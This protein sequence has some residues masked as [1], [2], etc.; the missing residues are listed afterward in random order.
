[1]RR[2]IDLIRT[3]LREFELEGRF[4]RLQRYAEDEILDHLRLMQEAGLIQPYTINRNPSKVPVVGRFGGLTWA[5]YTFLDALQDEEIWEVVK[6]V[7]GKRWASMP[8]EELVKVVA[9]EAE[10]ENPL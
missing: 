1:M 10:R 6:Q 2:D 9:G 4:P 8:L 5:G 7:T 3:L